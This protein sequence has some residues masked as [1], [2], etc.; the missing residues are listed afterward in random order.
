MLDIKEFP[1]YILNNIGNEIDYFD[2]R[3]KIVGAYNDSFSYWYIF[4]SGKEVLFVNL[5]ALNIP[6]ITGEDKI[7]KDF[8]IDEVI[9]AILDDEVYDENNLIDVQNN[10]ILM[11][12]IFDKQYYLSYIHHNNKELKFD[13]KIKIKYDTKSNKFTY[14]DKV[15]PLDIAHSNYVQFVKEI[16][17]S[18]LD[19]YQKFLDG[20]LSETEQQ[21]F[22]KDFIYCKEK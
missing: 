4:Y 15:Y 2:T 22:E 16:K 7:L 21:Q 18:Y 9:E 1:P 17:K 10:I 5:Y 3:Y 12:N 6:I 20:N 13:K 8:N 14:K 19:L 11:K